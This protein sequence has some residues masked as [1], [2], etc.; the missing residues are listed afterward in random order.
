MSQENAGNQFA[1]DNCA[2]I[3]P[4]AWEALARANRGYTPG[5]GDDPWTARACTLLRELFERDCEVFFCFNG[6]AANSLAIGHLCTS[7][8]SVICHDMAHVETDECGGPE[9]FTHGTKLFFAATADDHED[10]DRTAQI[11]WSENGNPLATGAGFDTSGEPIA[12][13][14]PVVYIHHENMRERLVLAQTFLDFFRAA[15]DHEKL[16]WDWWRSQHRKQ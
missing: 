12:G 16:Y 11:V 15:E 2:G 6:T 10:G 3:C 14:F 4:E 8:Q 5:Y 1:S 9:F 7:Y 13:E